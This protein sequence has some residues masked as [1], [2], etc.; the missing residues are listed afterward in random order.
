MQYVEIELDNV[1]TVK[2]CPIYKHDGG[3]VDYNR[4][5]EYFSSLGY[6]VGNIKVM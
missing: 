3:F 2:R 5:R 1:L 4:I 6:T